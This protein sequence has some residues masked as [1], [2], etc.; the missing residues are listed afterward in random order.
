M[1]NGDTQNISFLLGQISSNQTTMFKKIDGIA[2]DVT[3]IKDHGPVHCDLKGDEAPPPPPQKTNGF[4]EVDANLKGFRLRG[5]TWAVVAIIVAFA[6]GNF[7]PDFV[8][9]VRGLW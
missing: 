9:W 5:K 8:K 1:P 2:K 3:H 4:M 6:F 7:V